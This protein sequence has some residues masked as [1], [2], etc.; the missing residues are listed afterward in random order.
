V[1]VRCTRILAAVAILA[2]QACASPEP[3]ISI[4]PASVNPIGVL[5][6]ITEFGGSTGSTSGPSMSSG[7]AIGAG[8]GSCRARK[9]SP[10]GCACSCCSADARPPRCS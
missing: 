7:A 3:A 9:C 2:L 8:V 10:T 6:V 5:S 4:S 1:I